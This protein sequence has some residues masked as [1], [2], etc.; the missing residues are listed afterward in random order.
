M[1]VQTRSGS[2]PAA[3]SGDCAAVVVAGGYGRRLAAITGVLP[4][5][6]V[7]IGERTLLDHL[8]D[9]VRRAGISEVHLLLGHHA[10][11]VRAYIDSH[12]L[13][14]RALD[15]RL[16]P[17]THDLG[18]AGPLRAVDSAHDEWLIINGDVFTDAAL[19]DIVEAHRVSSAD[20][21]LCT[22]EHSM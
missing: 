16:Y 9:Q 21:T 5:V 22:T 14:G 15:I 18:T 19:A 20:L 13:A 3:I 6:L 8:L 11:L 7:P 2:A 1:S 4:K 10:E 17:R 12:D